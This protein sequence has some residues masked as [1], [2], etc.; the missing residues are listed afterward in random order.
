[1]KYLVILPGGLPFPPVLGGA[2]ENLVSYYIDKNEKSKFNDFI[3][4]SSYNKMVDF[5]IS[6]YNHCDF[7]YVN[8]DTFIFKIR[9]LFFYILR[10]IFKLKIPNAYLFSVLKKINKQRFD[11]II[12]ENNPE[13]GYFLKK[14]YREKKIY[15]HIHNDSINSSNVKYLKYYD[16]IICVSDFVK[17]N[18]KKSNIKN[19]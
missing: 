11:R 2:T 14:R 18:I 16:K 3:V 1:M 15:L 17:N 6:K 4:V 9:K 12:V 5:M 7:I 19:I 10:R 13:F 8:S